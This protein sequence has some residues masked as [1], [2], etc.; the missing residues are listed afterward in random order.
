[1]GDSIMKV[2][3]KWKLLLKRNEIGK[4]E[5]GVVISKNVFGMVR[6]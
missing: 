6:G 3:R 4:L 1:V 2:N 5:N